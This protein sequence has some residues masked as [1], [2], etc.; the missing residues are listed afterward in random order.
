MT[1]GGSSPNHAPVGDVGGLV[2]PALLGRVGLALDGP[3]GRDDD[4]VCV[5]IG[6]GLALAAGGDALAPGEPVG[7]S[8]VV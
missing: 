4:G 8:A 6:M 7:T 1:T 2:G 3:A 5:A